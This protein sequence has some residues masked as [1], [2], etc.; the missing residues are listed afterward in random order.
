ME[1]SKSEFFDTQVQSAWAS[2]SYTQRERERIDRALALADIG[3]GMSILEPGCGA[4]RLTTILA[5]RVGSDGLVTAVDISPKM[6]ERTRERMLGTPNCRVIH[7]DVEDYVKTAQPHDLI[8]CHNVF[9]HLED[10]RSALSLLAS[11]LEPE[12]KLLIFHFL[13]LRQI[14]DPRRK[15]HPAVLGDTIPPLE[16]MECLL[17]AVG[18]DIRMY[19]NGKDGYLLVASKRQ[20]ESMPLYR[21]S[22]VA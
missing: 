11:A 12:G 7:G 3:R 21:I 19:S 17:N 1:H 8:V 20:S 18:L 4:G 14:N 16:D 13:N 15:I 22:S 2:A 9:H 6:I 10:K 5:D